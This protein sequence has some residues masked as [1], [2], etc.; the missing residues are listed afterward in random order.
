MNG[1]EDRVNSF[2]SANGGYWEVAS[3]RPFIVVGHE[4][5]KTW[6]LD[7]TPLEWVQYLYEKK[8]DET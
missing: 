4:G 8:E 3:L 6:F 2:S 7:I 1:T 5:D